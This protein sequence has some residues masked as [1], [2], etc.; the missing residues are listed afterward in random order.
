MSTTMLDYTAATASKAL[1]ATDR[2]LVSWA[3]GGKLADPASRA[4]TGWP[5]ASL[6]E[7]LVVA[8]SY[9]VFIG[10]FTA[11][12]QRIYGREEPASPAGLSVMEKFRREPVLVLQAVYNPVQVALCGWMI[13]GA[14]KEHRRRGF[15]L[16]CN[17][18]D[19]AETGMATVLWVFYLSKVLD[20]LDT[21]F[22]VARRKW[23]QLSF[24]H[25]YHHTSIFLV[26]WLILAGG[27][28]GDIF[29]TI[30]LN[31]GIHFIMYGY[32]A[33]RTFNVRVPVA[34]KAL[35]TRSQMIQFCCMNAQ[36]A[37]LLKGG[38]AYPKALTWLYLFYIFS[39]LFLFHD[40]SK[41]TYRKGKGKG[42]EQSKGEAGALALKKEQGAESRPARAHEVLLEGR[43]YDVSSFRHPGGSIIKFLTGKGDATE[44]FR[45]F[46]SRSA[47]ARKRLAALPSRDA[48]E[49]EKEKDQSDDK[50]DDKNLAAL[51]RDFAKLRNELEAEG[52]FEPSAV[53]I[54]RRI[55]ELVLLHAVGILLVGAAIGYWWSLGSLRALVVAPFGSDEEEP[56][57]QQQQQQQQQQVAFALRAT[58][59]ALGTC[60]LGIASGRCGWLMHEAGHY[61]LTGVVPVDQMLQ[62]ILYGFG[63]GMSGGWWRSQHNRHH[64]TPQKLQHDVDLETLPLISFNGRIS[65]KVRSPL[66]RGWLR[67]QAFTFI[68]VSCVLVALGWQLVLHPRHILRQIRGSRTPAGSGVR[69]AR[70]AGLEAAAIAGRYLC[71][72]GFVTAGLSWGQALAAFVAYDLVAAAYIFTNFALSHTHLPVSEA[73]DDLHWVEYSSKHTTNIAPSTLCN[74]W[75]AYLNY[76][77]EHHLFPSMPQFRHPLVAPR[78][79]A[80]FERHGLTYDVRPYFSCLWDTLSNMHKVGQEAGTAA[81]TAR[82]AEAAGGSTSAST[83]ATATLAMPRTESLSGHMWKPVMVVA[84][85]LVFLRAWIQFKYAPLRGVA[86]SPFSSNSVVPPLVLTVVYL[87]GVAV[88]PRLM[89]SRDAFRIKDY[90]FTY[91]L[92]QT[93]LNA[94]CVV[95][96]VMEVHARGMNWWGNE[97]D[98]TASGFRLS[99]LIWIHYNNKF[100]ELLD[101]LFMVLR[102]KNKQVSVLHVYHHVM[103]MWAWFLVCRYHCGGD[104]YFGALA[105]SFI[106]VVMYSYY[107][108]ALIGVRCPWKRYL[109][110][111]QLLQFVVCF[112]H[113]LYVAFVSKTVEPWL[114]GVQIW[115]MINMLVLFGRFYLQSYGARSGRK[116]KAGME[117]AG[118]EGAQASGKG[119]GKVKEL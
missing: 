18:F 5:L 67:L 14:I 11:V 60:I 23:R 7:A 9:L 3:S 90:M 57:L 109:T 82:A 40:F 88:L 71:I 24:L 21:F 98:E 54:T 59:G 36:A 72:F 20:F 15:G 83:M 56:Q 35:I 26:Y 92:Y 50:N 107:G 47:V 52:F 55:A 93:I 73:D 108:L 48:Q 25:L 78:V 39:M 87:V 8:I 102:K 12:M 19:P 61:S 28:D 41:K 22:M 6:P 103:L 117:T 13:W 66:L 42:K 99:S 68:P 17:A 37:Y 77:I 38:C 101:T 64:A 106:H 45:E 49:Q 46:H 2:A 89:A 4:T 10:V 91:N 16:V 80:L 84:A 69:R 85:Y 118:M 76:Q 116:G 113:A 30:V 95:A 110:Q 119:G 114:C 97:I 1:A 31:G 34:I 112:A 43:L 79:R 75:M 27:Y 32:Y 115:V 62:A 63:C 70:L 29:F 105:N 65:A 104:S 58:A 86:A 44:A 74:W 51:G 33:L 96:F 111:L 81:E 53:E 94:W 100:V